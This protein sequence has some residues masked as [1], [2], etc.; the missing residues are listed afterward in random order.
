MNK[1]LSVVL[2]TF[3]GCAATYPA[4]ARTPNYAKL[5]PAQI[6]KMV[7]VQRSKF[8]TETPVIGPQS[9][10]DFPGS[11]FT[12]PGILIWMIRSWVNKSGDAP[13]SQI[14]LGLD[15]TDSHWR[16]YQ[17]VNFVG[18][19]RVNADKINQQVGDCGQF[20][21]CSFDET[22]GVTIPTEM[23]E[24]QGR[25][26]LQFRVNAQSGQNIVITIPGTYLRG[27][28]QALKQAESASNSAQKAPG[29]K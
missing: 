1:I 12:D 3:A 23:L 17:S 28:L 18:G 11:G 10:T 5:T 9:A 16:N 13:T 20:S 2:L 29:G 24:K 22:I 25:T 14:Y 6:A 7:T 15:Y 4:L 26:N 21:G 19:K 8:N 27:F